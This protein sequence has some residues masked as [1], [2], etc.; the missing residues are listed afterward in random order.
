MWLG[1][2]RKYISYMVE[3]SG[4]DV[5]KV[6]T[7][8]KSKI[9]HKMPA[10]KKNIFQIDS[11]YSPDTIIRHSHSRQELSCNI[12]MFIRKIRVLFGAFQIP[13]YLP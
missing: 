8:S 12:K 9:I 3:W 6:Y 5:D 10:P 4:I 1:G 7:S 2:T 13:K 11:A